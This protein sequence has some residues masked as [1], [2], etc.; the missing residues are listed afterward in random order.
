MDVVPGR[1]GRSSFLERTDLTATQGAVEKRE[2][3]MR[4]LDALVEEGGFQAPFG[5]K[6]D[7]EGF[8][9][10]VIKGAPRLLR[11]TEFVVAEL[12]VAERFRDSYA[13]SDFT[14]MMDAAGFYLWDI[15]NVGGK[16]FV[17]VA[18]RKRGTP[19]R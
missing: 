17:D 19:T 1:T 16:R 2:V 8:E 10:Q 9:D 12:S 7:A 4:T 13:F 3:P 5:L 11:D 15:L 14:E 6:I 18:F